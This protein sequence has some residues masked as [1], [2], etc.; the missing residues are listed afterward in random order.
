MIL[1]CE[2]G[3]WVFGLRTCGD[4]RKGGETIKMKDSLFIRKVA[5]KSEKIQ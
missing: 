5:N 1:L 4:T 2:K 3:C